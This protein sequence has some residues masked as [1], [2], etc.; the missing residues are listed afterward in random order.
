M[1]HLIQHAARAGETFLAIV[2]ALELLEDHNSDLTT[3]LRG[4]VNRYGEGLTASQRARL[5]LPPAAGD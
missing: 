4:A 5:G 1:V 2:G 3:R